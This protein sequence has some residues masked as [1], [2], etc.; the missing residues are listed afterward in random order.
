MKNNR[1]GKANC[2]TKNVIKKLRLRLADNPQQRLIFEISLFT[3]ERMG[4]IVQLEVSDVY[5][6][7]G[8]VLETITFGSATR[9]ASKHGRAQ[10]RQ[11][12]IHDDLK[13]HLKIYTPP[14]A[15]YLFPSLRS[16][17][18]HITT[19]A[20]DKLWRSILA[21][22]GYQ[23]YST[24]SSRRWVINS[25]RQ[26]GIEIVNIAEAM[27]INIATVRRYLDDDPV[28]C[29]SAISTLSV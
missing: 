20:V 2:W 15:G 14:Q 12:F 13:E 25:L 3:G 4:A 10:T 7:N 23:G 11:I 28:A 8:K 29:R 26:A 16:A 9:K 18:G 21:E 5:D 24:H 6:K 22:Y 19:R 27:G 17:C 1:K